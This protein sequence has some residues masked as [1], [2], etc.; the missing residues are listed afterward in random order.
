MFVNSIE[1]SSRLNVLVDYLWARR[2]AFS[3]AGRVDFGE[4]LAPSAL[5]DVVNVDVS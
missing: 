2:S 4:T 1:Q 5:L 3:A